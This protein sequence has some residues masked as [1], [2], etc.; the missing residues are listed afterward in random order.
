MSGAASPS[1]A[2]TSTGIP[3]IGRAA[4]SA[5]HLWGMAPAPLQASQGRR[6][7]RGGTWTGGTSGAALPSPAATST[8]TP[9]IKRASGSAGHL[10][11]MASANDEI[12]A[13]EANSG[14]GEWRVEE[15]TALNK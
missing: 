1:P 8:G 2:A 15:R 11:G 5:G 14:K 4:G 12:E 3:L 9:S 6:F 7:A 13:N 10:W